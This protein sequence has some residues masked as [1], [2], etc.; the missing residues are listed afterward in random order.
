VTEL[1]S[2]LKVTGSIDLSGCTGLTT[3]PE[4]TAGWYIDLSGCT[5]LTSIHE[6]TAGGYIDLSGPNIPIEELEKV[7][8]ITRY[9]LEKKLT[10]QGGKYRVFD[11]IFCEVIS[12]KGAVYKVRVDGKEQYVVDGGTAYS[13][14]DTIKEARDDL[15]YK[16]LDRDCS[17]YESIGLDKKLTVKE[18][19]KMYRTITGACSAGTKRFVELEGKL[20]RYYTVG[21]IIDATKG[22]Y[23]N[24]K[25]REF[26]NK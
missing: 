17:E 18:A 10:W 26:F 2:P 15:M 25:L 22:Q 7:K 11:G 3:I 1:P 12:K 21:E 13:H 8:K 20:K 14:G 4:L 23:G 6:L 24:E 5:G 19:I 16:L 9:E